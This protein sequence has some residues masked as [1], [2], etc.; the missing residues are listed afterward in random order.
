[1][2]NTLQQATLIHLQTFQSREAGLMESINHFDN[3]LSA[4][5]K[6]HPS[7]ERNSP[8]F[9]ENLHLMQNVKEIT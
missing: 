1:M 7:V 6:Q 5:V 9:V 8:N 3:P 2:V 4:I